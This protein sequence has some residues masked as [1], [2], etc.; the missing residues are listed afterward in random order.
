MKT[1]KNIK[2]ALLIIAASAA[3]SSAHA[4]AGECDDVMNG[5]HPKIPSNSVVDIVIDPSSLGTTG[6]A[7]VGDAINTLNGRVEGVNFNVATAEGSRPSIVVKFV[8]VANGARAGL[9]KSW[10]K[11]DGTLNT[12]E[13]YVYLTAT[14]CATD[15]TLPC[16]DPSNQA[17]YRNALLR[18]VTHELIH[19]LGGSDSATD[20][21]NIMSRFHGVNSAQNQAS[22]VDCIVNKLPA[23]R[24][25]APPPP[26]SS[27]LACF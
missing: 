22:G 7:I 3:V 16:F 14:G 4:V 5:G 13:I 20:D 21:M 11:A 24:S 12:G 15:L 18:V 19:S 10:P 25:S 2:A 6:S 26:P 9:Y 8:T 17:A 1:L 27:P 23:L